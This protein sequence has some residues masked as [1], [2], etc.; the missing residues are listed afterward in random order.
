MREIP[1]NRR[2]TRRQFLHRGARYG[3]GAVLGSMFAL[4]LLARE[5]HFH[6]QLKG[7]APEGRNNRGP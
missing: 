5:D 2:L 3:G 6:L 4:D 7:R 1:G